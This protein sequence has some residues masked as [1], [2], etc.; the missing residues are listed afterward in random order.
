LAEKRSIVEQTMQPG[1]RVAEIA[2]QH[3]I[4]DNLIFNW[5]RLYLAGRLGEASL[6][7]GH[8]LPV[9]VADDRAVS[10][11]GSGSGTIAIELGRVRIRIDGPA[12]AKT[13]ALV[14]ER[15]VR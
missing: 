6:R 7:S 14:L 3:G 4:N 12:D 9:R 11:L 15:V 1:V 5:R 8:L 10:A 13:L 2:R